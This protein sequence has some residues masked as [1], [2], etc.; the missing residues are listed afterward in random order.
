MSVSNFVI[1]PNPVKENFSQS[2]DKINM[3]R[4]YDV[5]GKLV[6][7]YNKQQVYSVSSLKSGLYF[8][9]IGTANKTTVKK[10]I[11]D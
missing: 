9:H 11:I 7:Q 5:S 8:L 6:K 3:L 4:I 2:I 10:I 1:Y